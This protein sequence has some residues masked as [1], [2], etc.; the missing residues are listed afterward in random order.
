MKKF[1]IVLLIMMLVMPLALF[2]KGE[3]ETSDDDDD[4]EKPVL[5]ILNHNVSANL[6][7]TV[8]YQVITEVSGYSVNYEILPSE[9][10]S[11]ILML[12]MSMENDYDC[13]V[14]NNVSDF[15]T[16]MS[17]GA[18]LPL[19]EYIDKYAPRLWSCVSKEAWQ[20]VS[21]AEGNVYALPATSSIKKE[22]N[23]NMTVRLDLAEKAGLGRELPTTLTEFYNYCKALKDYYG[24]EYTIIAGP[25]NSAFSISRC[26]MSAFGIYNDWMVD[27]NGKVIYMTEHENFKAMIDFM[28]KL[29]KEGILDTD[30]AINTATSTNS[31]FSS[32][33]AIICINGRGTINPTTK[34]LLK[35][36]TSI[37]QEDLGFIPF[38]HS[39]DGD[40]KV[41]INEG[42]SVLTMIPRSNPKNAAHVIKYALSKV[43]NQELFFIGEEGVHFYYDEEGYPTPIQPTFTDERTKANNFIMIKDEKEWETQ[44]YCRL[45]KDPMIWNMFKVC[46]IEINENEPEV[47]VPAYFAF[48][49]SQ[50]YK[51]NNPNL[52]SSLNTYLIQLLTGNKTL[53]ES[54]V[55]F[56]KDFNVSGG[57]QVRAELQTYY[58][59]TYK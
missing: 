41:M 42:Y 31:K 26:I 39:D 13:V 36:V 37:G 58:N 14:I 21:D 2:A 19:N 32:G 43:E 20:G 46:S 6:A 11:E 29:Y 49:T 23:T 22:I 52:R 33:K 1:W 3:K 28:L 35:N 24:D 4:A 30:Y 54:I 17:A 25:D 45:R 50:A 7:S 38:L 44:F 15:Q 10:A 34:A 16:L 47:W 59:E 18:L 9:H 12:N 5:H 40:A 56:N 8:E 55:D 57:E 48:T 51:L 53:E 27:D